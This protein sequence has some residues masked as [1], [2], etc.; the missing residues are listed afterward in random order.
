MSSGASSYAAPS[1]LLDLLWPARPDARP[2]ALRAAILIAV[3]TALLTLSAKIQVPFYPV[4]MTMQTFVVLDARRCLWLAPRRAPRSP[5]YLFEGAAGLPV[6]AG[7]VKAAR[8]ICSGRPRGF[9]LGFLAPPWSSACWRAR[10][11][12]LARARRRHDGGRPRGDLR[13][14]PRLARG[15]DAGLQGVGGRVRAVPGRNLAED[16]SRDRRHAGRMELHGPSERIALKSAYPA[17]ASK[18]AHGRLFCAVL[19]PARKHCR[20]QAE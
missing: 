8:P 13:V 5:L 2:A 19:M 7:P 18:A 16:R 9:L 20:L 1:T 17:F 3:G 4:P 15:A 11:G 14:R 10:L 6:L 12:P